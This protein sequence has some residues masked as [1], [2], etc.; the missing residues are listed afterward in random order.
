MCREDIIAGSQSRALDFTAESEP[1]DMTQC[2][3]QVVCTFVTTHVRGGKV[4]PKLLKGICSTPN[5][6]LGWH[7]E[8]IQ[9]VISTPQRP[10][11][12]LLW[13]AN[14]NALL[15][16]VKSRPKAPP[17]PR[18]TGCGG[19]LLSKQFLSLRVRRTLRVELDLAVISSAERSSSG[20]HQGRARTSAGCAV[21]AHVNIQIHDVAV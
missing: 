11:R 5:Q 14:R 15:A 8:Q 9:I 12:C 1:N 10:H 2:K 17:T 19:C 3:T 21:V 18:A 13:P 20:L 6:L 4:P 7:Y 16:A